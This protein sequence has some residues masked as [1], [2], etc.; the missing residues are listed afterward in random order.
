MIFV[1][2][3]DKTA[4]KECNCCVEWRTVKGVVFLGVGV[5]I[6]I[7]SVTLLV[8][9]EKRGEFTGSG[10][11]ESQEKVIEEVGK[12]LAGA[13]DFPVYPG[14]DVKKSF[15]KEKSGGIEYLLIWEVNA[16]VV[17]VMK[18]Y[19][20]VLRTTGWD[21]EGPDLPQ[22]DDEQNARLTKN[23]LVVNLLVRID[24]D[25]ENQMTVI[26]AEFVSF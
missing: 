22:S 4:N 16:P 2:T 26:S 9:R 18:W 3:I 11:L 23:D 6:V 12:M 5:V 20:E 14:A 13:P 10:K 1:K 24:E 25:G 15:R 7:L 19:G 8:N 17:E 21:V